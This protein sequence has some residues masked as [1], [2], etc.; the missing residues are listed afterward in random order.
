MYVG[1]CQ[2][3]TSCGECGSEVGPKQRYC[4]QCGNKLISEPVEGENRDALSD[5]QNSVFLKF[6]LIAPKNG[7]RN[8]FLGFI[9]VFLIPTIGLAVINHYFKLPSG[10]DLF[11]GFIG[12]LFVFI[13]GVFFILS[14]AAPF[15]IYVSERIRIKW[16][17]IMDLNPEKK[18]KVAI[19]GFFF[20]I[21]LWLMATTVAFGTILT[22]DLD[23]NEPEVAD[24]S[25]SSTEAETG[26][27]IEVRGMVS[28]PSNE[29]ESVMV[30]VS[31]NGEVQDRQEIELEPG[32]EKE[33]RFELILDKPGEYDLEINDEAVGTITVS[34]DP[35]P[36]PSPT[37]TPTPSP[38]ATPT[39][40]PTATPTPEPTPS[41]T[42]TISPSD[43]DYYT[44]QLESSVQKEGISLQ[45][46]EVADGRSNGGDKMVIIGY[47]SSATT[48]TEVESE[49]EVSVEA[50]ID[51]VN[52]GWDIDGMVV[53]L[54][55]PDGTAAGQY[56]VEEEWIQSYLDGDISFETLMERIKDTIVVY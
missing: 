35:T 44:D 17:G 39:P 56:H 19:W 29:S 54:G 49:M 3:M 28:N 53:I 41:P 30:E 25:L 51:T 46:I 31:A 24:T 12:L 33:V 13:G 7:L 32:E 55:E 9:Y 42:P 20:F 34:P 26:D 2:H 47:R 23:S 48:T 15:G 14:I 11:I 8:Y 43:D 45:A 37:A 40:S 5:E 22:T 52:H 38:T 21:G 36:T 1:V 27:P 50:F 16:A 6:P 18:V 10:M 4:Q